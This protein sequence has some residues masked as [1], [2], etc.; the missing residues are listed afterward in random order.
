MSKLLEI[1]ITKATLFLYETELVNALPKEL[2]T[3][4]LGRGKGILRSR[5]REKHIKIKKE[6]G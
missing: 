5:Q 1:R 4:A 6:K 3:K 2:F